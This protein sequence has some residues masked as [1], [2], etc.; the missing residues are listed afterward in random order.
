MVAMTTTAD[1]DAPSSTARKITW[2]LPVLSVVWLLVKLWASHGQIANSGGGRV[3]LA[4]AASALPG[5]V[6]AAIVAGAGVAL[7]TERCGSVGWPAGWPGSAPAWSS[8]ALRRRW[9]RSRTR[10]CPRSRRSARRL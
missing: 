1:V 2:L 7:L 10:T 5:V 6:H 3:A 4:V 8:A 9:S